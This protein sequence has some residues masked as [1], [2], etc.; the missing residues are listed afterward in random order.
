MTSFG[1]R[2]SFVIH[3]LRTSAH[4][5][6]FASKEQDVPH[7]QAQVSGEMYNL[8]CAEEVSVTILG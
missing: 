3:S 7:C 5:N 2:R 6:I 1:A 4:Y 8:R